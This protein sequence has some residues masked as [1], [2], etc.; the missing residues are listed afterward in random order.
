LQDKEFYQQIL[1][2][3][4]PWFVV[5]VRLD[6][7]EQ[8]VDIHVEHPPGTK[9]CCPQCERS[10]ACYD[11]A[12]PRQWRHLDTMQCK[13]ILH[14]AVPRV[15]CPEHGVK[16]VRIPWAESGSRFTLLFE[17]FAIDVLLA[18]QNVKGAQSILRTGWEQ[19]WNIVRRSVQRGQL[20]KQDLP[21]PRLGIDE[22]SFAKGQS[23]FTLLYDLDRS[24]VE[25]ISEGHDTAA[26]DACFSE[27]SPSQIDSIEAIAMDM[28]A[29]YV[30]SAKANIPL[31]EEKIVHDRFHVMK[32]ATEAVDK[33]RRQ[34]HRELKKEDDRRLTGT[35]FLWIKSQ[36]NLTDKQQSLFDEVFTQ[37]LQT[38]KAWAYKEMLRDLWH[39]ATASE[40]TTYFQDWYRSIIHT[41]LTPMKKVA[42]TIKER[43][44]N[45]VSYCTHGITNA[46]AE[47]INSKIQ[48]IKRRVGGYRN[49]ENYKTAI[50]FYCGGLKLY[51]H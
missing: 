49:K 29:A 2:I 41:K 19:T 30:K 3:D 25:V 11:H 15:E 27:L 20:R 8:Q 31:A 24:T 4:S 6:T 50:Y 51:P 37:Q 35:K 10:L 43:L 23:Y 40:A 34:E 7:D 12:S 32:L 28:S 42:R 26:A 45:V 46:V 33:V 48:A 14:A 16:Q 39:H 5:D 17:R 47:G 13:T 38:G 9:F 18:T 22:K 36:E 21:M 1:G 44:A